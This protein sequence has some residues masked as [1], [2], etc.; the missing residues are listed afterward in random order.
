MLTDAVFCSNALIFRVGKRSPNKPDSGR[1]I[2]PAV[3]SS[4]LFYGR[5]ALNGREIV[6]DEY[7]EI[8]NLRDVPLNMWDE[9]N[10]GGYY[11]NT[12]RLSIDD[13][14]VFEFPANITLQPSERMLIV[15]VD[16]SHN[17]R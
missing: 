7:I 15:G 17:N 1:L 12:W 10:R 2:S 8:T 6:A 11:Y 5:A 9:G 13:E 14:R 3:I 16:V 4:V